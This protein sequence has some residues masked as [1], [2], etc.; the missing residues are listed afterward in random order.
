MAI[1]EGTQPSAV[2]ATGTSGTTG[3]FTP[4]KGALLAALF[5]VNGFSGSATTVVVSDSLG[6]SWTLL[7]RQN[8]NT[9]GI[10]GSAEIWIRDIG[11]S[12][13][14]M[15]VTGDWSVGGGANAG[16][17]VVRTLIGAL[18]VAQQTGATGG[19]GGSSIPPTC[20]LSPTQIGSRIYGAG[21]DWTTNATL[22]DNAN[23]TSIDQFPDATN[24]DT[25]AT[26]KAA[27][28]TTSTG[29]TAYGWTNANAAYNVA[30]A[31]ILAA[32][33]GSSQ[34]GAAFHPGKG[35]L[36]WARF[37]QPPRDT[38]LFSA[39]LADTGTAA[40]AS[41][42]ADVTVGAKSPGGWHPGRGPT[43]ARFFQPPRD[44]TVAGTVQVSLSDTG[45]ADDSQLTISAT[46]PLTDAGSASDTLA[47]AATVPLTDTGTAA[48][49]NG[50]VSA[51][52]PIAD[53]ASATDALTVVAALAVSEAAAALDALN[54]QDLTVYGAAAV[55]GARHPGRGPT[56]A[57]FFQTPRSTDIGV[58]RSLTDTARVDD[59]IDVRLLRSDT[60][61]ARPSLG[62]TLRSDTVTAR[63]SLGTTL[64]PDT[65]TTCG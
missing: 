24:G 18:P 41:T 29:S 40:D 32:T 5:A 45:S 23:T 10:G 48:D 14:S 65:G 37:Y 59:C 49:D 36:R 16:N 12:P 57:R 55:G 13:A 20:S 6:G 38:T 11:S 54:V 30:A 61:T 62:T 56:N 9:A 15:T 28:D 17:I 51:T 19:A 64:R 44:Y 35:P 39:A 21:L 1:T 46:V 22:T 34:P 50:V 60:V 52:I 53:S 8:T 63:P 25:W 26:Y 58:A 47:V 27:V 31:E 7:K 42:V 4:E 43:S 3:A 33:V 2:H